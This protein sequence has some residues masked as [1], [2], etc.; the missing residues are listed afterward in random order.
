MNN[1]LRLPFF[2]YEI[3]EW[4]YKKRLLMD[5]FNQTPLKNLEKEDSFVYTNYSIQNLDDGRIVDI[6]RDTLNKFS[7]DSGIGEAKIKDSWFQKYT[8]GCFHNPHN[9]GMTGYSAVCYIEYDESIHKPTKFILPW[10]NPITGEI[11]E[12]VPSVKEGDIIMFPSL[13]TH[14]VLPVKTDKTRIILSL[15]ISKL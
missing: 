2:K 11:I 13:L 1:L 8:D 14:Y 6:L 5:L 10:N 9:H 3:D 4:E 12:Y 15:N 7:Y